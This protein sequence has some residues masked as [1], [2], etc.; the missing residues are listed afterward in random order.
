M[1]GGLQIA[2]REVDMVTAGLSSVNAV[3]R[4][5]GVAALWA[6]L[7]VALTALGFATAFLGFIVLMP[8][9]AYA[10]WHGY[11]EV[12]DAGEWPARD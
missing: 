5:K 2:D 4:N 10:A 12:V 9:L 8:W 3:L 7:I 6:L 1:V 11:R